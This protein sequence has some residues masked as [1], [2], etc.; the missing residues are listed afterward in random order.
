MGPIL[1]ILTAIIIILVLVILVPEIY[2]RHIRPCKEKDSCKL[3][4][5]FS[6]PR[7]TKLSGWGTCKIYYPD[8]W[9]K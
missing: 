3:A 4:K 5:V 8:D 1:Y 9:F 2:I 7:C 6:Y